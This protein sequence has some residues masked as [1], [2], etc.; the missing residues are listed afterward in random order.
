MRTR[1]DA[2]WTSTMMIL[3]RLSSTNGRIDGQCDGQSDGRIDG[4]CD[5]QCP[6]SRARDR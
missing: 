3:D 5:G 2:R 1:R 4:E 6:V